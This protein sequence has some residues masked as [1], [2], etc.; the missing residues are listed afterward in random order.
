MRPLLF[1]LFLGLSS[2][3]FAQY[4]NDPAT[5]LKE[6]N[7][8]LKGSDPEKTK[9]F[10]EE[11]EPNWLTN[12]S[13]E[14]QNKVVSTCNFLEEK[15]RPAFPDIYGY[16]I[17]VHTFVLTDQSKKSFETWHAKIDA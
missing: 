9:I 14:Y 1:V 4:S 6:I 7:K 2:T 11:F 5:F 3:L 8:R 16:L 17:S 13:E 10:M 12:F 15:R